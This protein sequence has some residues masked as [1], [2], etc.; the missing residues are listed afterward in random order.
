MTKKNLAIA[1]A[2]AAVAA[3]MASFFL[4][5]KKGQPQE[6]PFPVNKATPAPPISDTPNPAPSASTD[7][8]PVV[9]VRDMSDSKGPQIRYRDGR[10]TPATVEL[11]RTTED[12]TGC[13]LTIVNESA[14]NLVVRLGPAPGAPNHGTMYEAIAPGKTGIIDPRYRGLGDAV[15]FNAA[16]PSATFNV[17]VLPTCAL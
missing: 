17:R 10:F 15:F 7:A 2:V 12:S 14:T 13:L 11:T 1:I 3:G 16:N 8:G 4:L 5:G 6:L 9:Q